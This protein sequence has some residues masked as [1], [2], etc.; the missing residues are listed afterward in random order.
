MLFETNV[1]G[2]WYFMTVRPIESNSSRVN[3]KKEQ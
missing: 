1:R 3:F 2:I